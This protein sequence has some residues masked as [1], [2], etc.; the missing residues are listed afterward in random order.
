MINSRG[1]ANIVSSKSS[2]SRSSSTETD[3][4]ARADA[5]T[6]NG[7]FDNVVFGLVYS[8]E[9]EDERRLDV[10]EGVPFAYTK[11][12]LEFDFWACSTN[13]SSSSATELGVIEIT[14][15]DPVKKKLLVYIDR[16]RIEDSTP[17][18]EYVYRMNMGI[19]DAVTLGMPRGYV[20][21]VMRK[22]IPEEDLEVVEGERVQG[23][24]QGVRGLAMKQAAAF[25]Y[26][27]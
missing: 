6:E 11:E 10:N 2:A 1:Y 9:T 25:E 5:R 3:I 23:E 13:A 19:H 16:K 18:E 20:D 15:K 24:E 26:E 22:F 7:K 21:A 4:D 27:Q 8:L 12:V 17:H 14:K